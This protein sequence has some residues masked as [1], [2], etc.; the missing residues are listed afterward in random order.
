MVIGDVNVEAFLTNNTQRFRIVSGI[1]PPPPH[2]GPPMKW[3]YL[4]LETIDIDDLIEL[5]MDTD[6][7]KRRVNAVR[8]YAG[9]VARKSDKKFSV[10]I[11][12]FG[13]GIWRVE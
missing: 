5:T 8:S 9:R 7:A 2:A 10:R 6:E 12:E 13:I 4:P 1:G 11:T 3:G